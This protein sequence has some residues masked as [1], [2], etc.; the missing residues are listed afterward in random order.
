[1]GDFVAWKDPITIEIFLKL[2]RKLDFNNHLHVCMRALFLVAFS[3]FLC[4]QACLLTPTNRAKQLKAGLLEKMAAT[5][6]RRSSMH[7]EPDG[8]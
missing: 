6:E 2:F 5:R 3:S 8:F 4:P 1:M 7:C